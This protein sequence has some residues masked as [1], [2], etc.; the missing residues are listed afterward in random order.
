MARRLFNTAGPCRPERHYMLPA[1]ERVASLRPLIDDETYFVL[2]APRQVGKTTSLRALAEALTAE[3]TYAALYTSCETGQKLIPDLDGSIQAVLDALIFF[4]GEFLPPELRPP[5]VDRKVETES[6]LMDLLSRWSKQCPRPVVVFLDEI[7]ALY[8][9]AL[10]SILRQL[11]SGFQLR[12]NDFP[13][14]VALVGLRDVRDYKIIA[15]GD[16][17]TLGTSSPFNIKSDSLRLPNFTA[18]EVAALYQQHTDDTGQVFSDETKAAAYELTRGQP[19]LVNAL[20]RQLVDTVVPDRSREITTDHLL[21]AKEI[22]IRRRDTH[23]DSLL[24]RLRE[25]RVRR[26]LEPI[27]AGASP[28]GDVLDDDYQ[29][30]EDLGLVAMGEGGLE[31]ANPIYREVIPR[32]L[33]AVA[34]RFVPMRRASYVFDDGCLDWPKLLDGFVAFW[35][36]HAEWMLRQQPY[37]EAAAQ[38]VF[39]AFLHRLVNGVDLRPADVDPAGRAV[40]VDTVATVDREFAVGSGRID[41]MVRWPVPGREPQR[42]AVE[43]KVRRDKAGDP[44]QAGLQ[45]LSDY[46][47]RLGLDTGTLVLFDLRTDAPPMDERGSLE[48]MEHGGRALTVLRL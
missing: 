48:S 47:D 41:L 11:R 24:D 19:W 20:A 9:D 7:D 43:L 35:K 29:F 46:L 23:L 6:R 5:A 34:E 45:Q 33:T 2:H 18:D 15:R 3:G 28:T 30:V 38:L 42:F 8:D 1:D 37:S 14:S 22:L 13:Q 4:A 25:E 16:Q 27:L 17:G 21:V 10:I 40:P 36:Q 39:M 44:L 26:V 12:P 32:A 31:I